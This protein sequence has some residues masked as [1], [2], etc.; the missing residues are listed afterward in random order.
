[1]KGQCC[2]GVCFNQNHNLFIKPSSFLS[3]NARVTV[4]EIVFG[5]PS[6][7][8]GMTIYND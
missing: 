6:K 7:T 8:K 3:P 2:V 5:E 1:M 4:G